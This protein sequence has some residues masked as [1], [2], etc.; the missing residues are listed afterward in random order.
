MELPVRIRGATGTIKDCFESFPEALITLNGLPMILEAVL[1]P[2]SHDLILAKTWIHD[3]NPLID[4]KKRT[5][6]FERDQ[7]PLAKSSEAPEDTRCELLTTKPFSR[8]LMKD[9]VHCYALFLDETLAQ[10]CMNGCEELLECLKWK[11]SKTLLKSFLPNCLGHSLLNVLWITTLICCLGQSPSLEPLT[12]SPNLRPIS[13]RKLCPKFSPKVTFARVRTHGL[14]LCFLPPKR[15]E[16]YGFA[17][18]T[19]L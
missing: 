10:S 1:A 4:R 5:L 16:S 8:M 14:P 19:E 2:I 9:K 13:L 15:M 18:I 12:D 6:T 3:T 17:L 7:R 11:L